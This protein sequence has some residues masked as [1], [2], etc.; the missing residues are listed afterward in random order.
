MADLRPGP[1]GIVPTNMD[2][3]TCLTLEEALEQLALGEK[4]LAD[5]RLALAELEL[6]QKHLAEHIARLKEQGA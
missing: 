6:D 4:E 5:A 1:D 2:H 3:I